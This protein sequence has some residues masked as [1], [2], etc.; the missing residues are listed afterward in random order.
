MGSFIR[1][2]NIVVVSVME[3][4]VKIVGFGSWFEDGG[5]VVEGDGDGVGVDVEDIVVRIVEV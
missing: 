2:V 3:M 4:V 5:L 1:F